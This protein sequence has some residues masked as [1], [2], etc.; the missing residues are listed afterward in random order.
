ML[1]IITFI[2]GLLI[3]LLGLYILRINLENLIGKKLQNILLAC[4]KTNIRSFFTGIITTAILQSSSAITILTINL[5]NANI[6]KFSQTIGIILGTNIGTTLTT[7]M[8]TLNIEKYS[9]ILIITGFG[10]ILSFNKL[11]NLGAVLLGLG[12]IFKGLEIIKLVAK[13]LKEKGIIAIFVN[14]DFPILTGLLIGIVITALI[15]SSSATIAM[16]MS[17]FATNAISL[18]FAIAMVFGS[19]IGTCVT[20]II[21]AIGTN[22]AAKQ[23]AVAH[24]LLNVIG[25][26]L[27]IPFIPFICTKIN[28]L[29][30]EKSLQIAHVQTLFN[31]LCSLLVL[32][33]ANSFAKIITFLIPTKT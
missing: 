9:F 2:I 12:T 18:D 28:L 4:T 22:T 20:G 30:T 17:F 15:H 11:K 14:Q 7:E 5:V 25:V 6:L 24:I 16:T 26:F 27:F 33:F 29:A 32:P 31:I 23:V 21:A 1:E 8:L 10:L 3:F 19:N 13:P